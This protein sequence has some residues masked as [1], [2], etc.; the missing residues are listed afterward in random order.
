MSHRVL[1][2]K[3]HLPLLSPRPMPQNSSATLLDYIVRKCLCVVHSGKATQRVVVTTAPEDFAHLRPRAQAY[4][5][6]VYLPDL[7]RVVDLRQARADFLERKAHSVVI[8]AA[9]R[10]LG[11]RHCV[12]EGIRTS[13]DRARGAKTAFGWYGPQIAGKL[14]VRSASLLTGAAGTAAAATPNADGGYDLSEY[15]GYLAKVEVE[16]GRIY[17]Q[18]RTGQ[19]YATPLEDGPTEAEVK[20]ALERELARLRAQRPKNGA[21]KRARRR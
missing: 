4:Q 13:Q 15:N 1:L 8:V 7:E 12:A 5:L 3:Y 10:R 6:M 19:P 17:P 16:A 18:V 2:T 9:L 11:V 14:Y 20:A 21:S